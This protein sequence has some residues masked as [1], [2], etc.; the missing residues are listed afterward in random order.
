MFDTKV[1]GLLPFLKFTREVSTTLGGVYT[2]YPIYMLAV[3]IL[4][5]VF[6]WL[7]YQGYKIFLN[8]GDDH[9]HLRQVKIQM[10]IESGYYEKHNKKIPQLSY[11]E[12]GGKLC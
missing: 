9:F 5:I 8:I 2:I 10:R 6:C 12:E 11:N 3:Y 1:L 7:F 4:F